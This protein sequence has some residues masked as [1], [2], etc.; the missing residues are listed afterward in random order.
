MQR[1]T[2]TV[3]FASL[4]RLKREDILELQSMAGSISRRSAG[5]IIQNAGDIVSDP[6]L[7]LKGWALSSVVIAGGGRQI[8]KIHLPGDLLGLTSLAF[9]RCVDTVTALT[10]FQVCAV[11]QAAIGQLFQKNA[12]LAALLFLISLEE[13]VGLVD[14]LVMVGRAETSQRIA[15]LILQLRERL[16]LSEPATGLSFAIPLT[17]SHIADMVG[18][19]TVHVS[20]VV[21]DLSMEGL[22]KWERGRITILNLE[23]AQQFAG[24]PSR[25]RV[26]DPAW[27]PTGSC[28]SNAN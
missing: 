3:R 21:Q 26:K 5:S 18:A 25:E 8:V 4:A 12:R 19:T 22:I 16:I 27:L 28:Q 1:Q 24:L 17:Q 14:R 13:R 7:L 11:P 15:A 23:A 6:V 9:T 10:E 2:A 20:R